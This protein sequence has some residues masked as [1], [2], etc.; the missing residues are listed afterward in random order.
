MDLTHI[1]QATKAL[2][3]I[4]PNSWQHVRCLDLFMG[5]PDHSHSL[6]MGVD[7][8]CAESSLVRPSDNWSEVFKKLTHVRHLKAEY[9][10][11]GLNESA[12]FHLY[13]QPYWSRVTANLADRFTSPSQK[14]IPTLELVYLGGFLIA[15]SSLAWPCLL[16]PFRLYPQVKLTVGPWEDESPFHSDPLY[17][18]EVFD[19][20]SCVQVH[21]STQSDL[22]LQ[23]IEA[24]RDVRGLRVLMFDPETCLYLWT[25]LAKL[26]GSLES[27]DLS[28]IYLSRSDWQ[29]VH[30]AHQRKR[31]RLPR[32]LHLKAKVSDP[33]LLEQIMAYL[34]LPALQSIHITVTVNLLKC[35]AM[36]SALELA[37]DL[38][39]LS[40]QQLK[41]V[42]LLE[43]CDRILPRRC[44]SRTYGI[45]IN[46]E[47][48]PL[49][50]CMDKLT[51]LAESGNLELVISCYLSQYYHEIEAKGDQSSVTTLD[52][53]LP[54]NCRS[55]IRSMVLMLEADVKWDSLGGGT[56]ALPR[57]TH[58]QISQNESL[59]VT[60]YRGV[61]QLLRRT[62]EVPNIEELYL[63]TGPEDLRPYFRLLRRALEQWRNL[64]LVEITTEL[65]EHRVFWAFSS[66]EY[67]S[68]QRMCSLQGVKFVHHQAQASARGTDSE[69]SATE[70]SPSPRSSQYTE[71]DDDT[72]DEGEDHCDD[73][74]DESVRSWCS[75]SETEYK[76]ASMNDS[77]NGF[78]IDS[79]EDHSP[80][81]DYF[82]EGPYHEDTDESD[83]EFG[84]ADR[85]DSID[86][87]VNIDAD[88]S[89]HEEDERP[90][91]LWEGE[92]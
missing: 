71:E 21:A 14:V 34:E 69:R 24:F 12:V 7:E 85:G 52:D 10:L 78:Q 48:I 43:S 57:L 1:E 31:I 17:L 92:E 41:L 29:I 35:C 42:K 62:L 44:R 13:G 87:S 27:L 73:S 65:P 4:R 37:D 33:W 16:R 28:S 83:E 3:C 6:S 47:L 54:L 38:E 8:P 90:G 25:C 88:Y 22:G 67:K 26:A 11:E 75:A 74:D 30:D 89:E 23:L 79:E 66:K 81:I 53:A 77:E 18:T 49:R 60:P 9:Q 5:M 63:V 40:S 51:S 39:S 36:H 70:E 91:S 58:L 2:K 56:V 80:V 84:Q 50:R 59:W 46:S 61:K 68:F 32:L 64:A 55:S 86:F 19:P 15:P 45:H 20:K 72:E 82:E 76:G